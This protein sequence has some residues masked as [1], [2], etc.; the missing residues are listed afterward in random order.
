[1]SELDIEG[2]DDLFDDLGT[3]AFLRVIVA[4]AGRYE[5]ASHRFDVGAWLFRRDRTGVVTYEALMS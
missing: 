1:M 4:A 2:G 3:D 5:A